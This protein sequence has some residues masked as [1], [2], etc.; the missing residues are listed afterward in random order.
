MVCVL[1][2]QHRLMAFYTVVT[3]WIVYY[4]VQFLTGNSQN[5]GFSAMIADPGVNVTYL[6]VT[7]AMAFGVLCFGLQSG[8]SGSPNT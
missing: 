6:A 2:R 5:L 8:W 3:G 7:V 1:I 4:F